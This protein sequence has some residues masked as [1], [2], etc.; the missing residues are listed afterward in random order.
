[1]ARQQAAGENSSTR[2]GMSPLPERFSHHS[3]CAKVVY[4]WETHPV[5]SLVPYEAFGS[6]AAATKTGF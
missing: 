1:M 4:I 2:H 3:Q 5:R 6:V